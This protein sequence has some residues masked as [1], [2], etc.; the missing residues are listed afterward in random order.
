[1]LARLLEYYPKSLIDAMANFHKSRTEHA[2]WYQG[3]EYQGDLETD[4]LKFLGEITQM[5]KKTDVPDAD[6][7][8]EPWKLRAGREECRKAK[9]KL[10]KDL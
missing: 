5:A 2:R 8:Q 4:Y 9:T 6:F 7:G 3:P 10:T 1:M